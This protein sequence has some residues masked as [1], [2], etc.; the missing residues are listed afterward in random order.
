MRCLPLLHRLANAIQRIVD[1]FNAIGIGE[2]DEAFAVCAECCAGE[3]GNASFVKEEVCGLLRR[4][5]GGFDVREHVE[6]AMGL[7]TTEARDLIE[8]VNDGIAATL[9]FLEEDVYIR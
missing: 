8:A 1:L 5:A 3:A 9:E 7:V 4:H 6:R 2:A